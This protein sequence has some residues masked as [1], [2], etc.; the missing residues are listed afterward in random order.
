MFVGAGAAEQAAVHFGCSVFT[1]PSIIS[2]KPV[3][4]LTSFTASP[5]SRGLRGAAGREQFHAVAASAQARSISP[6]LS[7]TDNSARDLYGGRA[8]GRWSG[9]GESAENGANYSRGPIFVGAA[10]AMVFHG[11]KRAAGLAPESRAPERTLP[12]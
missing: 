7:D 5:A 2:R 11:R 9:G 8:V 10:D 4:S 3:T 12:C 1:R 6:V